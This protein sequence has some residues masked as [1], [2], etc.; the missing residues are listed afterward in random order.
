[1][2]SGIPVQV[3]RKPIKNL[4]LSVCPPDGHMRVAIPLHITD[5]NVRLAVISRLK[6]IKTQQ[7]SFQSQPR[8][9]PREM[10]TG[11]SHYVFGKR[12]R[13][14]VIEQVIERRGRHEVVIKKQYF[15]TLCKPWNVQIESHPGP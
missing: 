7:A 5:D 3:I 14:E 10:V 9:S 4:H 12:Y 2:V 13:L 1:M 15:P 8:Q 6:W 11:E